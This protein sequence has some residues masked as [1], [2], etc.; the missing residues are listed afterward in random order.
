VLLLGRFTEDRIK[1]LERLRQKLRGLGF[2]PMV[3]DFDKPKIR[4]FTETVRLLANLS[5]F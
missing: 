4:D 2:V 5:R 3:F 1:I